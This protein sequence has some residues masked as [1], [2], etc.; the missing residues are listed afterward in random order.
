MGEQV[1]AHLAPRQQQ[2]RVV[3]FSLGD[4]ADAVDEVEACLEV[5]EGVGFRQM[6]V[7]DDLPA[8]EP[9]EQRRDLRGAERGVC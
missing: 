1:D 6:M 7:I 2:I 5:V 9:A 8:V 4:G 3:A